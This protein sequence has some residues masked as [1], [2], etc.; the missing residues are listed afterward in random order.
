MN[1][2]ESKTE[3]TTQACPICRTKYQALKEAPAPTCGN[4]NCIREARARGLPITPQRPLPG[5]EPEITEQPAPA[6]PKKS[7]RKQS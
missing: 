2:N 1:G 3:H 4:P 7:K 6:K 5:L